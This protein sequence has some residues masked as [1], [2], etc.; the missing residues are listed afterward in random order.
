MKGTK[1]SEPKSEPKKLRL[2]IGAGLGRPRPSFQLRGDNKESVETRKVK[3][4]LPWPPLIGSPPQ[5]GS[6]LCIGLQYCR[7]RNH[8]G[9]PQLLPGQPHPPLGG[10]L[11]RP[12]APLSSDAS[13]AFRPRASNPTGSWDLWTWSGCCW[14]R[15]Q[16]LCTSGLSEAPG[17]HWP[18]GPGGPPP[19]GFAPAAEQSGLAGFKGDKKRV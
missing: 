15:R 4:N 3:P 8:R 16:G 7:D 10:G 5:G 12:P 13:R 14:S 1:K 19:A 2:L 6:H 11:T 9:W 17:G 18:E